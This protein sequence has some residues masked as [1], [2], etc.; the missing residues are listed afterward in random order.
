MLNNPT[1]HMLRD[2]GL[3][4]MAA[5]FQSLQTQPKP[6]VSNTANGS[7]PYRKRGDNALSEAFPRPVPARL[8]HDAQVENVDFR[9][10][11]G[12]DRNLFLKLA[13]CDFIVSH[14]LTAPFPDVCDRRV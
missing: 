4:G 2:L 12:L 14:V 7:P 8:R 3:R 5:A 13:G 1:M 10:A 11:R 9:A 6:T